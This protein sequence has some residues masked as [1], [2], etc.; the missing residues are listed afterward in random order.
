MSKSWM[1]ITLGVLLVAI[2]AAPVHGQAGLAAI[3]NP[4]GKVADLS[5]TLKDLNGDDVSLSA[6]K[7]KVILLDF[8]AT[9]CGPCKVEIPYF[10]DFYTRYQAQGLQVL[11]FDVDDEI[12]ALT[13]YVELMKMNYPILIGAGRDDVLK[14]YGPMPGLPTTVIIGRDGKVCMSHTGLVEKA[15]FEEAIKALL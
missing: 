13:E 14:A 9:W 5:F 7:G 6:F 10:I 4:N 2:S 8:W 12:P 1:H 15:V 3:C 11:G